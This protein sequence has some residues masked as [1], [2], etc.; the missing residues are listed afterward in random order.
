[1]IAQN[2]TNIEDVTLNWRDVEPIAEKQ[3]WLGKDL[4]PHYGMPSFKSESFEP[5]K[6]KYAKGRTPGAAH[7]MVEKSMAPLAK[8]AGK[9]TAGVR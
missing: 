5:V 9:Q 7:A 6:T 2:G 3:P 8:R 1:M 4:F